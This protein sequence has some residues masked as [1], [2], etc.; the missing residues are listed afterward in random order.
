MMP[1][2]GF[3]EEERMA[4][5]LEFEIEKGIPV[6]PGRARYPF[7]EMEV[8]DS[9]VADETAAASARVW[10]RRKDVKFRQVKIGQ[11]QFRVWRIA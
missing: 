4:T 7:A 10:G 6:P 8:G 9:F 11:N 3:G 1:D 2:T 5:A